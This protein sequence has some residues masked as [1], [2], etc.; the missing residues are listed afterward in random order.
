MTNQVHPRTAD[1]N[2]LQILG[3]GD[4]WFIGVLSP[5]DINMTENHDI[6]NEIEVQTEALHCESKADQEVSQTAVALDPEDERILKVKEEIPK[7][8]GLLSIIDRV[9]EDRTFRLRIVHT[10]LISWACFSAVSP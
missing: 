8:N 7:T 2:T 1:I 4:Q 10:V 5:K 9:R 3:E 6:P